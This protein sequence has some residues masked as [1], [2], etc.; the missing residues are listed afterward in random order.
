LDTVPGDTPARRATSLIVAGFLL[1]GIAS[2][3]LW[4]MALCLKERA[5][6]LAGD[7]IA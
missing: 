4:S 5:R 2:A 6:L 1:G 7:L 3:S